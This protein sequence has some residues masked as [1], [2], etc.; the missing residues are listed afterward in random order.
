MTLILPT[1]GNIT[2]QLEKDGLQHAKRLQVM[3]LRLLLALSV[4]HGA[5][6]LWPIPTAL[7]MGTTPLILSPDFS[8]NI[9]IEGAPSDLHDAVNQT[10]YYLENDNSAV[11]SLAVVPTTLPHS[12]TLTRSPHSSSLSLPA[13]PSTACLRIGQTPRHT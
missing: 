11:L 5:L 8:F 6:V 12:P 2:W 7:K 1:E 3:A 10:Q 9:A 4:L 13:R